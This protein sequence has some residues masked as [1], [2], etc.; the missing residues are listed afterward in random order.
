M[1]SIILKSYI[2]FSILLLSLTNVSAQENERFS[3]NEMF[4]QYKIACEKKILASC[5][6]LGKHYQK[7]KKEKLAKKIWKDACSKGEPASCEELK[8][9]ILAG[10]G[11][12]LILYTALFLIGVAMVIVVS[13]VVQDEEEYKAKEKLE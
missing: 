3:K 13:T 12:D 2:F 10:E 6:M 9:G 1:N 4:T 11:S 7:N 8:G 5:Y